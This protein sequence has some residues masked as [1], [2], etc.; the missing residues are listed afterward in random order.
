MKKEIR[1]RACGEIV[2]SGAKKC[3][4]CGKKRKKP[5]VVRLLGWFWILLIAGVV[6]GVMQDISSGTQPTAKSASMLGRAM[7]LTREQEEKVLDI[8]ARC[9]IGELASVEMFQE[10]ENRTSYYVEDEETKAY[11]G[12]EYAIVVWL[13]NGTKE[14]DAIYF[15]SQDIYMNGEVLAKVSDFYVNREERDKYR[16]T[17]QMLINQLLLVPDSAK[18]PAQSGWAFGLEDGVVIVQSSV[19]SK[20]AFGVALENR[21]QITFKDGNPISLILDGEEYIK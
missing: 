2:P 3:P 21:F 15:H 6:V 18:Y 17:A 8:F 12:A 13:T 11:A 19:K 20:N 10:G 4:A 5:L 7:D 16:V 14:I 1:C 9:G